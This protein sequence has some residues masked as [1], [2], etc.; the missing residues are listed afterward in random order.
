MTTAAETPDAPKSFLAQWGWT[1]VG[2]ILIIGALG[3]FRLW[4]DYMKEQPV[5]ERNRVFIQHLADTS[6]DANAKLQRYYAKYQR[7]TVASKHYMALCWHMV[8]DA[9]AQGAKPENFSEP[10]TRACL[11]FAPEGDEPF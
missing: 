1:I 6:S 4:T 5:E 10:M 11:T 9:Q 7:T 3:G 2:A 8:C